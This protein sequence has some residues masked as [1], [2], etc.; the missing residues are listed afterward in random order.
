VK[1]LVFSRN[2]ALQLAGALASLE[3]NCT[4][5]AKLQIIVL[6]KATSA[7]HNEAYQK[8][9]G[10]LAVSP[11]IRFVRETDFYADVLQA[12]LGRI[13]SMMEKIAARFGVSLPVQAESGEPLRKS[14]SSCVLFLV[15]DALFVASFSPSEIAEVLAA[16]PDALGVSLRLGENTTYC[17]PVSR[18]QAVPIFESLAGSMIKFRWPEGDGDFGYPFD[19]SSSVYRLDELRPLLTRRYF[20]NPNAMEEV[21]YQQRNRVMR[22]HPWLF[23]YCRSVAF[24][25]PANRVQNV[26]G[27]RFGGLGENNPDRLAE[28]FLAGY[29]IDVGKYRGFLPGACH[30]EVELTLARAGERRA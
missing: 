17:Y 18:T 10:E 22:S 21:L 25:N 27:N 24:S 3:E 19:L 6:F 7:L 8:L 5:F 1:T 28:L 29:R 20:S 2:R 11:H 30:Q 26:A 14:A 4:E 9:I 12:L 16:T 13:P 23:S 15:D